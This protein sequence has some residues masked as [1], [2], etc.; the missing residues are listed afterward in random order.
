MSVI[1][2]R[3]KCGHSDLVHNGTLCQCRI[4]CGCKSADYAA[5]PE[6]IPSW[7]SDWTPGAGF[8][9]SLNESTIEPGKHLKGFPFPLADDDVVRE[10]YQSLA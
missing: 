5:E 1:V 10:L 6:V 3:C 4:T 2:Y 9:G 7:Q 8:R